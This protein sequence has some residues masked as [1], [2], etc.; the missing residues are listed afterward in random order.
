MNSFISSTDNFE[1]VA[2][3]QSLQWEGETLPHTDNFHDNS[4]R[5]NSNPATWGAVQ[6]DLQKSS[7]TLFKKPSFYSRIKL[8]SFVNDFKRL[9][10]TTTEHF[11]T[12]SNT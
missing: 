12:C 4:T 1:I 10:I 2:F 11:E 5:D 6:V 7:S 3:F 9:S 8:L